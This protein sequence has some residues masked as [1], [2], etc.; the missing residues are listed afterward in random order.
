VALVTDILKDESGAIREIEVSDAVRP[1]CHRVRYDLDAFF[2]KWKLFH[3][4]R[5]DYLDSVPPVNEADAALLRDYA[6]G[7]APNPIVVDNG[8]FSNYLL[9]QIAVIS[10]FTEGEDTVEIIRDGEIVEAYDISGRTMRSFEPTARGYY[11]ARLKNNGAEVHFAF[12]YAKTSYTVDNGSI[13]VTADPCDEK[14]EIH[15][16]DFRVSGE[17]PS[18]LAKYEVLTEEEKSGGVITRKIPSDAGSFKVYYRNP[19]GIWTHP[20]TPIEK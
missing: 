14:S 15:Y 9:G 11:T 13:T 18:A 6:D 12:L 17:S 19:Y 1:S 8:D 7:S 3:L 20:L 16:M 4:D 2:E 5:Y 10:T